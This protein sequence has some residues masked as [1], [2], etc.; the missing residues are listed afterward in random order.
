MNETTD[1]KSFYAAHGVMTDPG[2]YGSLIDDLPPDIPSLVRAVQGLFIHPLITGLYEVDLT[3][4]QRKEV[5]IRPVREM[6]RLMS[7]LDAKPLSEA[8]PANE[9]VVGN[10]RDHATLFCSMLRH[11]GIPARVRV[12][13][14]TYLG[15]DLNA[16]HWV[17]EYWS[18]SAGRWVLVDPQIDERQRKAFGI[19]FDTLDMTPEQ[20]MTAGRTWTA[21]RAGQAKSGNFGHS[22][23]AR[24]I[25]FVR[26]SLVQELAALNK[27][28]V[29]PWDSWWDLTNKGESEVTLEERNLLDQIA[30][31]TLDPDQH[32][33]A[34][35]SAYEDDPQLAGPVSSRLKVL[36]LGLE[37]LLKGS[38]L[39][40]PSDAQLLQR[41]GKPAT[42]R[43]CPSL[44][45][46]LIV[47]PLSVP[48][49]ANHIVIRGAQQHNLKHI[50]VTIPR[51]K[52]V[53]LTGVSAAAENPRWPSIPCTPRASAAT[54]RA[55]PPTCAATWTRWTSPRSTT[56]AA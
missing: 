50:D 42:G 45:H 48:L 49:D 46:P 44:K 1:P 20:F 10:C 26:T 11:K 5:N 13:F 4:I 31:Y 41:L 23:H 29:L 15:G 25:S 16:D 54:W 53:V 36:G 51:N 19:Q 34:L 47:N 22:R 27:V 3:S 35:R 30:L 8:R 55:F 21:I 39:L 7:S 56:S 12:G 24:G 28:E 9:R 43:D 14:A 38:S 2:E 18:E 32:F 33:E 40:L 37:P 52:L 17:T 6:L